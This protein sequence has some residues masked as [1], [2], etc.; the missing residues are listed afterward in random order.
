MLGADWHPEHSRC[1]G[2]GVVISGT[3][4][5]AHGGQP[6]YAVCF[7]RTAAPRSALCRQPLLEHFLVDHWGTRYCERHHG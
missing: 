2:C 3:S 7:Q 4:Y 5:Y 1:G 6:Y